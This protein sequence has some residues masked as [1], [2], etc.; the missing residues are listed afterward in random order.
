M[1]RILIVTVFLILFFQTNAQEPNDC[2]NAITVCGNGNFMSNATGSGNDFE[3]DGCG[4]F[5]HNSIWLEV[6]IVQAG[7]LGFDLIPNDP[8][9]LVDYD[10]WVYG[11]NRV[12]SNLGSPIRCATTNPNQAGLSN[13]HTGINGSTTLTQSGPGANG[14]GYVFW[15]N[16]N[17]GESYYI[18]IDR[19]AGDGGFELQWTGTAATGTGAFPSP[20]E[21]NEI[22][23][24][25]QCSSNPDIA[26]FD[27]NSLRNSINSDA[28]NTID[29][30]ESLADA[31][32]DINELPGIYANTSN[33]QTIYAKVKSAGTDCY[34]LIDF[35]LIV[36]P[37]PDASLTVS[38]NAICEGEDVTFTITGTP[39]AAIN[40]NIDG[41]ASQQTVL[42]DTGVVN[43]TLSPTADIVFNLE[44]AQ[45]LATDGSIVCSQGLMDSETVTV[46]TNTL[47]TIINNS[48]IC[49]GEDG[50]LQFSG[51]PNSTVSYS[52]DGGATQTFNFDAS[53]NF[54]LSLPALTANTD[55]EVIS[56]T[57]ASAPNCVLNINTTETIIVNP[58]PTVIDPNPLVECNDGVNPNSATF[59]LDAQSAAISNNEPNVTVSYY[60]TQLLAETGNATDA[61]ASPYDSTS[62]NQ[63]IYVRVETDL[64]CV[65]YTTLN[66]Q[67][68]DAPIANIPTGLQACDA[69]SNGIGS[70]DLTETEAE[71]IAGNTQVVQVTYYVTFAEAEDGTPQIADPT[72]FQNTAAYNQTVY[73]R[74]DS[75]ATDCYNI[76]E[77][78]LEVFDT[79]VIEPVSSLEECDDIS[80]NGTE[81][82][83][84][85]SQTALLLNGATDVTIT[86]HFSLTDAED[87]IGPLASP[88]TNTSSPQTIYV[89]AEND[90]NTD[91]YIISTFDLIVTP[92]PGVVNPTPLQVCDDGTP[93][94]ITSIDLSIKD[95]EITAN[96][97]NYTVSYHISQADA[98]NDANPLAIPYTNTVN[99]QIIFARVVDT[100]TGCYNTTTLELNVEQAPTAN[101]PTPLVFCDPDSDGFGTFDLTSKDFEIIGGDPTL[102]VS[103]HDTMA[104]A[105][106][107]VDALV[108]PYNNIVQGTQIVYARVESSTIAT[109]C[110]TIVELELIVSPTPQLGN[111]PSP[112]EICD[113]ASGDGYGQFDLT[114]KDGEILQNLAD[115]SQYTVSYY[116][117]EQD[118]EDAMNAIA[119][120]N[121]YTNASAFNQ[122][123][124]VR[125]DDDNS[126]CYKLTTLELIVN[127]L[128]VLEQPSPLDLCDDNNPGD[129]VEFFM[130]DDAAAEILNGQTGISLSYHETQMDAN[131]GSNPITSPYQNTVNPQ[132]IFVRAT[133][134]ATGCSSTITMLLRVNPIPSPT[135]PT[136][137]EVC[138]EDNDG[139]GIFNLEDKS[140][141]II[142]GELNTQVTYHETLGDANTG[143]NALV[144]PYTN[145]VMNEQT[146][147]IRLTN[148][149]TG[150][151][152]ASETLTIRVVEAPEVPTSIDDLTICDTDSNGFSA[153]DLTLNNNAVI[154]TQTGVTI[155]YHV[156]QADADSGNNPISNPQS[157]TNTSNPQVIY[158]RLAS[159]TTPCYD[160]GMFNIS[161][162]LPPVA[163]SPSPLELCDDAIA[164]EVTVFDLTVKNTEITG[165]NNSYAVAYY[166]TQAEA[167][168]QSNM[169]DAEAYTNTSVNGAVANPQTIYVVVTDTDTGCVDYTT[170]TLRVLPNPT[171]TEVLPSL[172]LCD[173]DNAG[174]EVEIFDLTTNESLLLNGENGVSPTY[175]ISLEDAEDGV[176]AIV[177]P[178]MYSNISSPQTIYVRVTNNTT[179]CFTIVDFEIEVQPLPEMIAIT[180]FI[181]CELNTDGFY[182]FNLN[183]KNDEVLNGQD[184]S[185]FQVTYHISQAD[186]DNLDNAI[187]SPY[188]N[189]SN[190]QEIFVAITNINTGCSVSTASFNIEVQ[191]AAEANSDGEAIVYQICDDEMDSDGNPANNTAEFD[192]ALIDAE[193]LDGQNP[194][195][196]IVSYYAT[197][198]DANLNVN[199][200]PLLYEN[201]VNPQV[202]YARVDND[203]LDGMGDDTSICFAVSP[204]TLQINP[205]PEFSLDENYILCVNTNGT[206]VLNPL[207]IDTGLSDMNYNFEWSYNGTVIP[208]ETS[209]SIS[210]TQGGTY[211]VV[212]TD[213][214]TSTVTNCVSTASTLVI[215]SEPPMLE[216][217]LVTQA[218]ASNN[219]IEA[220]ATGIGEYEYSLDGGPWQDHGTF[221]NVTAGEHQVTARDKNGCGLVS[222]LIFVIDYPVYFTPNGDGNNDTW[223]ISGI[224]SSAKI[225]I[226]DRYGKLLK[227]LSPTGTGW[228]GTFNG[229]LMPTNDYWF[230]VEYIEPMTNKQKE[231]RAHFTLKR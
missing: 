172:L 162:E 95:T 8:D 150:C 211:S 66:L 69:S 155:T 130:L 166:E 192:L 137:L 86:Y 20:P 47:P 209:S 93:D 170:L 12:C 128:P 169:I 38:S 221:T 163:V 61:L 147:Y 178:T 223:N 88:Y 100:V 52:I 224:G 42:D 183:M 190:P 73:A 25:K 80:N 48:P 91:C 121:N 206:E 230:V 111:P 99:G 36:T 58:L 53:G 1:N 74:V 204:V 122:I 45:I 106:N 97:P 108:S 120:I 225:Y 49:E 50:E 77:I 180:D 16:V 34:T 54:T 2:V 62:A 156:S 185:L 79:P 161:V 127:A 19:P 173:D 4:G 90:F 39:D 104:N 176:D 126:D 28:G 125:V 110:D 78:D 31:T 212:V 154:G 228:N 167:Q 205:L 189:T 186:A 118:A 14:N 219:V 129:E 141:E 175:H 44:S 187:V 152:N 191:E 22:D 165:G 7:T 143:I 202:I 68:I 188:I 226:Y 94:G 217:N 15:L 197:E 123:I 109:D 160:T 27:L 23:D 210:P 135:T 199:P 72:S 158:V 201:S 98:D 198:E 116:V 65:D 24:V 207:V 144:S 227:Q 41:G 195:N 179:G 55:V 63:T 46:T 203:T 182:S 101:T 139:F 181:E 81:Q 56:V 70:F 10:F 196:Y 57:T 18:V 92:V 5:E 149:I 229:N 146:V 220:L 84:L 177:D 142:G 67:V 89:R 114:S 117:D 75:D 171:P 76:A 216:V 119:N 32:D 115:P 59:N 153:F 51:D 64:G 3:V 136:D 26:I 140:I 17:V 200:L 168:S 138:D 11:P 132:N 159:D 174:D 29:F 134:D 164:D 30:Y 60:E 102:T 151:Y 43:I 148:T 124:W 184:A 133:N 33:P 112:L 222:E 208:T 83:D 157:Y 103:Y 214:S 35:D 218:F 113:D 96:N 71:V 231:F 131:T 85:D 213:I 107:N 105:D 37:I 145:I 82:F 9:I 13:N 194:Q 87:G 193:V 6:N 215:E 21:A 40:Y